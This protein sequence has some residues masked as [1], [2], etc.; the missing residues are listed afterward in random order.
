MFSDFQ[1]EHPNVKLLLISDGSLMS[2]IKEKVHGLGLDDKVLFLGKTMEV[3][4]Y[5]Q[6]MDVFVLPSLHE[7]LPVVLV[8]AQATGLPCIV[9]DK[10]AKEA[11]LTNTCIFLPI[12]STKKWVDTL[13]EYKIEPSSRLKDCKKN[14]KC[15]Q[16]EGYDIVRSAEKLYFIY[17]RNKKY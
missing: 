10:V 7:G 9:S 12:D 11:D 13:V 5:L 2:Q 4:K 8:E 16:N 6:A 3:N 15:L 14:Q 1:K 17:K